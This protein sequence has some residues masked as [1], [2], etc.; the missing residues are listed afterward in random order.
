V[1]RLVDDG[2]PGVLYFGVA[3]LHNLSH[4]EKSDLNVKLN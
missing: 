2:A 1:V 3:V 4:T